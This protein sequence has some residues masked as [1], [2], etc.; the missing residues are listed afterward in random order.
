MITM[1][2]IFLI[3]ITLILVM[4][5]GS[6]E[7]NELTPIADQVTD[8][9]QIFSIEDF[10]SVG[11]KKSKEYKVDELPGATSAFYG[12]IKNKLDP[13]D[14][15][16]DYELRF[17]ANHADA[18]QIGTEYVENATGEDGCI[19]KKC[20][21][22]TPDLKHRQFL[23]E[24]LGNAHAGNG[25]PKAKYISYLIY[26]NM[27]MMCPGYNLEDSQMRCSKTL[28]DVVPSANPVT[29]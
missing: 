26:G 23:A 18:V 17:Y 7:S 19:T 29:E 3:S 22:W 12:F 15:K 9:D 11:F 13:D 20:A 28:Y 4:G 27:I 6:G 16:I 25:Q 10:K 14:Q 8:T 2:N 5:C 1:K 24:R 21:L